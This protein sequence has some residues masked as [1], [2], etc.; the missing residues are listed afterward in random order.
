MTKLP[1]VKYGEGIIYNGQAGSGK[2]YKLCQLVQEKIDEGGKPII[3]AF[4]NKAIV[5]VKKTLKEKFSYIDGIYDE[6]MIKDGQ[7]PKRCY[8]FNSYFCEWYKRDANSLENKTVFIEEFSM[9]P[10]KWMTV[11]YKA[12]IKFGIKIHMFGDPNQCDP[13]EG[14][15][16]IHYN[17]LDS[18]T[19]EQVCPKRKTLQYIEGK[20]RYDKKTQEILYKFLKYGKLSFHLPHV[21]RKYYKNIFY[22][23]KTRIEVNTT[24]CDKFV[25]GKQYETV[26]FKYNGGTEQYK[27]CIGMIVFATTNIKDKEIYNTMEFKI[28]GIRATID[29]NEEHIKQFM[30]ER[31]WFDLNEFAKSFIPGFCVTVYKYQGGE[32]DEPYNIYDVNG[33][34]KKQLYT[35][36]SR[37]T[38]L[39]YIHLNNKEVN[40]KYLE[41]RQPI[42]ELTNAKFNSLYRNGKI[43]RV[44]FDDGKIYIGSTCENLKLRLAWHL[45]NPGSQVYKNKN[46]NPK[47]ELIVNAPSYDKKNLE[48]AENEHISENA[49]IYGDKLINKK[50]NPNMKQKNM[51]T[52]L[53]LK[54]SN[55]YRKELINLKIN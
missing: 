4:T 54:I 41:R 45:T 8:T 13:V 5:N 46:K 51:N 42:L 28:E 40:N 30:I 26:K 49:D 34:D 15:I 27:V 37:T 55:N 16:Q 14:G 10:N 48:K 32:I 44:R 24:C 9:V 52:R 18:R 47:I 11:I 22:L 2:T 6:K 12:F 23:N 17:Y 20:N 38:K 50:N 43:Y 36:L 35:A 3:L 7:K 53:K 1:E 31:S 39:E 19:M 25:E 29:E 21:D 33:M